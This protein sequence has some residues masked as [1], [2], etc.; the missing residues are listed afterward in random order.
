MR[1]F[2]RCRKQ[3]TC[4]TRLSA[5]LRPSDPTLDIRKSGVEPDI[6]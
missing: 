3:A 4:K 6:A 1:E 2:T 5:F